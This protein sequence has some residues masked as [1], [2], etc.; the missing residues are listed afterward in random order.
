MKVLRIIARD[1]TLYREKDETV[2]K[3]D[4]ESVT[5]AKKKVSI[6]SLLRRVDPTHSSLLQN[7]LLKFTL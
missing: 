6:S 7:C 2:R 1:N 5:T 4:K 3:E